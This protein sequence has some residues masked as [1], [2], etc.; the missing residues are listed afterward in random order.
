LEA[1][2]GTCGKHCG[3][4][5][6]GRGEFQ[7]ARAP[8]YAEARRAALGVVALELGN[9]LGPSGPVGRNVRG[10]G[11]TVHDQFLGSAVERR[12]HVAP[13]VGDCERSGQDR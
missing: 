11:S 4:E 2:G 5:G 1:G 3:G 10:E 8:V 13:D 12:C 6:R 7:K 9:S